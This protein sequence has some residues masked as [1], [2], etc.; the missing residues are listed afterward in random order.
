MD[1]SQKNDLSFGGARYGK[2]VQVEAGLFEFAIQ[3]GQRMSP[4]LRGGCL[5]EFRRVNTPFDHAPLQ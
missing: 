3:A 1:R 5:T 4:L 2:T